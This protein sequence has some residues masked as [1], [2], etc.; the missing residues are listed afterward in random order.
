MSDIKF[1]FKRLVNLCLALAYF[2]STTVFAQNMAVIEAKPVVVTCPAG[3]APKVQCWRGRDS[4]GAPYLM[5]TPENWTGVLVVHA[6][7]GPFLGPPTD[8]RADEDIKRWNITLVQ[9]HA[10]AASV[11]RQGGFAVTAAAQDTER[12]R[13]IFVQ[14]IAKP[15]KTLLHG[16]SWGAMVATK[17][18]ELF[19]GSWDGVLLT[20]GVVAGPTSYDF[21]L[22]VRALYQYYCANHPLPAEVNY[23]LSLGLP[24]LGAMTNAELAQRADDCLGLRKPAAQRTPEQAKK[25]KTLATLLRV[26]ESSVM[27]HLSWGTFT[28]ADIVYKRTEGQSPFG[29]EGVVYVGSDDDAALNA[30][31]LRFKAHPQARATLIADTD[32]SGQFKVPVVQAHGIDD[33]TVFVEGSDTLREKMQAAGTA[34]KLVQVF[35]KSG[36]HSYWGDPHYPPL[37]EALLQ[38]VEQGKKP[39]AASVTARC[40][41]LQKGVCAFDPS[42]QVKPLNSR[43]Y[44]RQHLQ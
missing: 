42:Y 24:K 31:V 15:R 25:L 35:V 21:R 1:Y 39:S 13:Q 43:V 9:G 17:A 33:A 19:P 32:H 28:L 11:F 18:A 40:E 8:E 26:P 30:N 10:W 7:G 27:S 3:V 29:N 16:Q 44:P 41:Q 38:W 6:H 12:V 23:A 14:H 2:S 37:F 4:A 34:E 20:S 22:D 5:A 36:E